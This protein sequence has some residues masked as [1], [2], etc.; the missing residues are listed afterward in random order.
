MLRCSDAVEQF[1]IHIA[2][3][4]A[5]LVEVSGSC[6]P[7]ATC[8]SQCVVEQ[9]PANISAGQYDCLIDYTA[10]TLVNICMAY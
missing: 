1:G 9:K 4:D 7:A 5:S 8:A 2:G 10:I 3:N 6:Q